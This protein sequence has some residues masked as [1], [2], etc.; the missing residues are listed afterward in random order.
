MNTADGDRILVLLLA[1]KGREEIG[2]DLHHLSASTIQTYISRVRRGMTPGQ[3]AEAREAA[4]VRRGAQVVTG[5]GRVVLSTDHLRI[6]TRLMCH[7]HDNRME[8]A[9][10]V[11][12]HRFTTRATLLA[13]EQ[14][15]HD[16]TLS[17]LARIAEILTTT[18]EDL[19]SQPQE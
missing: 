10:F 14:G 1:G 12:K 17:E 5:P 2:R 9:T 18:I 16:F 4:R 13:M 8:I 3:A 15:V 6:G 19:V 11:E 7:R